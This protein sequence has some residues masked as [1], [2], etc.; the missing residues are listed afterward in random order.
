MKKTISEQLFND[1]YTKLSHKIEESSE[2]I[3]SG[4]SIESS[5]NEN[6]KKF[7]ESTYS[8]Q[9]FIEESTYEKN[10][11]IKLF[12]ENEVLSILYTDTYDRLLLESDTNEL[13]F[14]E[15]YLLENTQEMFKVKYKGDSRHEVEQFEEGLGSLFVTGAVAAMAPGWVP[16]AAFGAITFLGMNL[17]FPSRWAQRADNMIEFSL[18]SIAKL[19]FGTKSLLAM[20]NTSLAASNRNIINFD[21]IDINPEVR[22]L[23]TKLSRSNDKKGPIEGIDTIVASC[24]E[25]NHALDAVSIDASTKPYLFGKYSPKHNSVFTVFYNS[26]FKKAGNK[27]DE[28]FDTLIKYRKCL[29]EKLV[30]I[31]KFLMIANVSQNKDYR[32]IIRIMKKGFHENPEQLLS[33]VHTETED[34][35]LNKDNII[36]LVKF[37]IFLEDMSKDLSLG[38]F[39]V[40][41]E[42]SIFLSQKLKTVDNEIEDY[43]SKNQKQIETV[44]ETRSE[45]A[46]KD[47]KYNPAPDK[48]LKRQLFGLND[49][50]R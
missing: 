41:R 18:G 3:F 4:I 28:E 15:T 43:L 38:S 50:V 16:V 6:Y 14:K 9:F 19:L 2:T 25:R 17:L 39:D 42:S 48:N 34:E 36:T 45:F 46:R 11:I 26:V 7:M 33:F 1:L 22:A 29:S 21:N 49:S 23:F 37:R 24:V 44:F 20:G 31:Y 35:Q 8:K 12:I 27:A 40:D 47:F 32:K 13:S 10:K 30:D 5:M